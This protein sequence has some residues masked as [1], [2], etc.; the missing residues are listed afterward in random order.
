MPLG[1]PIAY[2]PAPSDPADV[3][4]IKARLCEMNVADVAELDHFETEGIFCSFPCMK[5][6]V[7]D[8]VRKGNIHF[9]DSLTLI[10]LLYMKIVGKGRSSIP[11]AASWRVLTEWGGH[12]SIEQFR[13][14][15]PHFSYTDATF[16]RRPMMFASCAYIHERADALT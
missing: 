2:S 3:E 14:K 10:T 1:A 8:E 11:S 4:R 6:Y 16:V 15:N 5:A 12:L 9:N 13:A 7:E